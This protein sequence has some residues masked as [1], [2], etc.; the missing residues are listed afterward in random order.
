MQGRGGPPL[1]CDS[2]DATTAERS[3]HARRSRRSKSTSTAPADTASCAP[4]PVLPQ[5]RSVNTPQIDLRADLNAEDDEG[6][7]WSLLRDALCG[8][9]DHS[10]CCH[11]RRRSA[12]T[13]FG[14][15]SAA[16]R[17]G[18]L[19]DGVDE[20]GERRKLGS[21]GSSTLVRQDLPLRHRSARRGRRALPRARLGARRRRALRVRDRLLQRVRRSRRRRR[22]W[23]VRRG[24]SGTRSSASVSSGVQTPSTGPV[25]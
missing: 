3:S 17:S 19:H 14:V 8:H 20:L 18:R 11:R 4:E 22:R 24:R 25:Q 9:A 7:N 1:S 21:S 15:R 16:A 23:E 2:H 10:G 13:R 5:E 6:L 12:T